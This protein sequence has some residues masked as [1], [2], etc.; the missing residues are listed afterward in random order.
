MKVYRFMGLGEFCG[1]ISGKDIV[2]RKSFPN[3]PTESHGISFTDDPHEI[4][5]MA[6]V[7]GNGILVEFEGDAKDLTK[8]SGV[9]LDETKKEYCVSSY[10]NKILKPLRYAPTAHFLSPLDYNFTWFEISPFELLPPKGSR[11]KDI[12]YAL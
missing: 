4:I 6:G 2:K 10:N 7:I 8:S 3:C 1:M 5:K 9:S 12:V 11:I